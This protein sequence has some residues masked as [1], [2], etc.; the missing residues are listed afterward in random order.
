M[1][2]QGSPHPLL[3]AAGAAVTTFGFLALVVLGLIAGGRVAG[4]LGGVLGA[5]LLAGGW[6]FLVG[7]AWARLNRPPS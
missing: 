6:L 1:A 4:L 7:R 2:A 3:V 5:G